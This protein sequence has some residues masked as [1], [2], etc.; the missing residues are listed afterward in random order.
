MTDSTI[1][2]SQSSSLTGGQSMARQLATE[3]VT[4]VFG[5]PGVQLD[6]ASNGLSGFTDQI[7]FVN[8]RHEQTTTYAADGYH[9]STGKIGVALVVPGP[10]VLNAGS[11]LVTALACSSK[12]LLI[13]GQIPSNGIGKGYGLLHEIPEQSAILQTLCRSSTLVTDP[14]QVA[15]ALH[16]AFVQ[17]QNG[18]GPVAVELPPD[19]LAGLSDGPAIG[20]EPAGTPSP[21]E[22]ADLASAAERL[23]AAE[24]PVIFAGGGARAAGCW[25]EL[26]QLAEILGAPLVS[27]TNGKGSFDDRHPLAFLPLAWK[28][29]AARADTVLFVGSRAMDT[30]GNQV[31]VAEGTTTIAIN[32]NP[33]AFTPPRSFDVTVT[34]DAKT[35]VLALLD[36]LDGDRAPWLEDGDDVRRR[37]EE[38]LAPLD[39]QIPYANALRAAMPDD[40]VLVNEL[41]QVGYMARFTYDVRH[42]RS[43]LDPGYQG[44]LGYGYPTAI[45]AAVGNPDRPVV[46]VNGDGGFGYGLAE[47][48]TVMNYDIPL[49]GVV[50]RDDAFGNVQRMQKQQFDGVHL[51]TELK[52]PDM[53]ALAASF[54][55][56]GYRAES[57]DEFRSTLATAI[58]ARE[59]ALIDVPL[60]ITPDPWAIVMKPWK[61]N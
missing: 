21:G 9:R 50:F 52:N 49:V 35:G 42:P 34:G 40:A 26:T 24:R 32:N 36:L 7:T 58:D 23:M 22:G 28:E 48:A 1:T 15:G 8:A 2:E 14:G 13:S 29:L 46:S 59:P 31:R 61:G 20:V 51:G 43:Y 56:K 55:M 11:G 5:I 19:I 4:H 37:V 41:T 60:G 10:G 18:P 45:G 16:G 57:P 6:Y 12:V 53:L 54:G 47:M 27:T 39:P 33:G 38:S 3:G 30:R 17:L 25:D 44:T